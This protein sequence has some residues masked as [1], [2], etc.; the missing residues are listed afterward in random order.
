MIEKLFENK[1][2]QKALFGKLIGLAKEGG[3][4]AIVIKFGENGD[5]EFKQYTEPVKIM[6][7][8]E[9]QQTINTLIHGNDV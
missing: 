5:P 2:V 1:T 6:T 9:F 4:S 3:L 8:A 7:E